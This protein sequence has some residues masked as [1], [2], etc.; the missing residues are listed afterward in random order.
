M[1]TRFM[2]TEEAPIHRNVKQAIVDATEK[3]TA[4]MFRTL[5]NTARVFKNKV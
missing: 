3:D 2:C 5:K 1:G 4:L